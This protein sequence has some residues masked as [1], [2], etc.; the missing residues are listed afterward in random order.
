VYATFFLLMSVCPLVTWMNLGAELAADKPEM[1]TLFA[2][3]LPTASE[4]V[5]EGGSATWAPTLLGG[6][7]IGVALMAV[8]LFFGQLGVWRIRRSS[9]HPPKRI[10]IV[11]RIVAQKMGMRGFPRVRVSD[12]VREPIALGIFRP[13]VI[14]PLK[15]L[16]GLPEEA[17]AAAIAHELAHIRRFDIVFNAIQRGMETLFFYHPAVWILSTLVR[18]EREI[19]CDEMAVAATG[20]R[21]AYAEMLEKFYALRFEKGQRTPVLAAAL[22]GRGGKSILRRV[23][24]VLEGD[25]VAPRRKMSAPLMAVLAMVIAGSVLTF[26]MADDKVVE[27]SKKALIGKWQATK[28]SVEFKEDGT[29]LFEREGR[30]LPGTYEV[31]GDWLMAKIEGEGEVSGEFRLKGDKLRFDGKDLLRVRPIKLEELVGEWVSDDGSIEVSEDG[32]V[33]VSKV[34]YHNGTAKDGAIVLQTSDGNSKTLEYSL[35]GERMIVDGVEFERESGTSIDENPLGGTWVSGQNITAVIKADGGV[36]VQER[37]PVSAEIALGSNTVTV[38]NEKGEVETASLVLAGD[39]LLV[40]GDKRLVRPKLKE[41]AAR[42]V[43]GLD[44]KE[45]QQAL[46]AF[47]EKRREIVL[48][49]QSGL[50]KKHPDIVMKVKEADFLLKRCREEVELLKM[51]ETAASKAAAKDAARR[52]D[53]YEKAFRAEVEVE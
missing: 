6:W 45:Y 7:S 29:L 28:A 20:D 51:G 33:T 44:K 23:R 43:P 1:S 21:V 19:C 17:V 26:A 11:A 25:R 46:D 12:K 13:C 5:I 50:G 27:E 32:K 8:R 9:E 30:S 15:F 38:T 10:W 48:I 18:R 14:L 42:S 40:N 41:T 2:E 34:K 31:S 16:T 52:V 39:A 3:S 4:T 24:C 35:D 22:G 49:L 53:F 37:T 36:S 47:L